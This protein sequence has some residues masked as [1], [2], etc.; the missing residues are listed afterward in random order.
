MG[1]TIIPLKIKNLK[2]FVFAFDL[3]WKH[4]ENLMKENITKNA[5]PTLGH[6]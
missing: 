3:L 2:E 4:T 5:T 1:G 6:P